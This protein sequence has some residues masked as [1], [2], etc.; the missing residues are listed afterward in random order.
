[1]VFEGVFIAQLYSILLVLDTVVS[2]MFL[3]ACQESVLVCGDGDDQ[4]EDDDDDD[5]ERRREVCCYVKLKASGLD[6]VV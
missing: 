3:K 2:T 6:E 1:M 5:E 4:C